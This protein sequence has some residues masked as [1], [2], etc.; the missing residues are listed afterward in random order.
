MAQVE[1]LVQMKKKSILLPFI[2]NSEG[3]SGSVLLSNGL[4]NLCKYVYLVC[5]D[6]QEKC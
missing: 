6:M 2:N 1:T 5:N 3:G 4:H